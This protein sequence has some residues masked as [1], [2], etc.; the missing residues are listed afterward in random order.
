MKSQRF[1]RLFLVM[2]KRS[3][4]QLISPRTYQ[5]SHVYPGLSRSG[6]C[7]DFTECFPPR[8]HCLYSPLSPD[9]Y[10]ASPSALSRKSETHASDVCP[11]Y[12][13]HYGHFFLSFFLLLLFFFFFFS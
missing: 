12:T 9:A 7:P 11:T 8:C 3:G 6:Q 13:A 10:R 5:N 2:I 1:S 4:V